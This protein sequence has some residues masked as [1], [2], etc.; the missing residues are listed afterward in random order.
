MNSVRGSN[1][2][3]RLIWAGLCPNTRK[4]F[5]QTAIK[6]YVYYTKFMGVTT[7]P[8]TKEVL[9]NWIA[10]RFMGSAMSMQRKIEPDTVAS[11]LSALRSWHVD[12]EYSLAPFETPRIKLL[13]QGGKSF[14]PSITATRLP[15]TQVIL[16]AL[17][18]F[19]IGNKN[20]LN[21]DTAFKVAW[22]GFLRLGELTY[23]DLDRS[24][25]TSFKD[26]HLTRL[27]VRISEH[28]Q[29]ATLRLK[30][31][32]TDTNHTRVLI[33]LAATHNQN[34]PVDA[35]Q[36]LFSHDPQPPDSPLFR[37]HNASFSQRR[38]AE[39]LRAR[40]SML[41][42][43]SGKYSRHSFRKGA[44]QHAADNG[45]LD[46]DIQNWAAGAARASAYTL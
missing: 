7:W 8:A 5:Y 4:G 43:P 45:M 33:M 27:D 13:L 21:L 38:V 19:Q 42:I 12:H 3:K 34:C 18:S 10:N 41:D 28:N 17:T 25:N 9:E 35:L 15:I 24:K 31:S 29:Y 32:K 44:A 46:E 39:Q 2:V 14:F 1:V 36:N 22:A 20:D 37:F 30:R 6:S 26:L 11:Y 16:T 40:L 23:T